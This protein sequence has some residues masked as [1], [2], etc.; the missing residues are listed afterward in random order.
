[1]AGV[2]TLM[3]ALADKL[4][5][6]VGV[7][8]LGDQGAQIVPRLWLNPADTA[9]DIYPADPFRSPDA[10]GF[11]DLSGGYRFTVRARV[12][13]DLDGVQETLLNMMDDEHATSVAAAL[14]DD[15][16]LGGNAS[17]VN[18]EGPTGYRPYGDNPGVM[19]GVEWTVTVLAAQS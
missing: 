16:T 2:V 12:N 4:E 10:A 17:S 5:Q 7:T 19:L 18:V 1:V 13:G 11:G 8:A 9:I 6:V 14:E 3:N 15:Q